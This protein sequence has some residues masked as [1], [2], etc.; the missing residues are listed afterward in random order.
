MLLMVALSATIQTSDA[1]AS[2]FRNPPAWA[3]PHT[4]WHWMDGNVT[5]EG[6]TA[7]LEAMKQVGIGGAQMFTVSQGIPPGKAGY[8]SPE[9]RIMT[10]F[11]VDEANRL[12]VELCIHNCAGWSS[13]GGP[14]IKPEDAMQVLAWSEVRVSGPSAMHQTLPQPKAPQVYAKVDYYK[15]IEVYAFPT[16]QGSVPV[17]RGEQLGRT[18]VVRSDGLQ[19]NISSPI[20]GIPKAA[21]IDIT[22]HLRDGVLD[23]DVPAGDW[24]ILRLGHVPTGIDNH[25]APPE[26]DGLE[27]DKLSRHALDNHWAGMMAKVLSDVG[28]LAGKSLN[29]A[30]IDSYEVGSQNWTPKFRSEFRRL[31]GYDPMPY[32]PAIAGYNVQ[33]KDVTER[34]LWDMRRTIA[35]LYAENYFGY[36]AELCHRAGL[37]FSTEPYGD[38]GFDNIQAGSTADIPMGEFWIGG[39]AI[40]STKL[41]SSIGHVYGKNVIGAESFTAD[42]IRGRFLEEP[43]MLKTI[44]DLAWCNGINRYIFHRYAMQPWMNFKPGMT[45]GP[46]GTH[47]ERTQTWWKEAATWLKYV[48]RGQYLLQSGQFVADAIVYNGD[49]APQDLPYS[50]GQGRVVPTGYDYDGC[51]KKALL[52]MTVRQGRVVLPSGMSYSLLI[53]PKSDFM[54]LQ[55]AQKIRQLRDSGA[56]IIG[57]EPHFSPTLANW[58]TAESQMRQIVG[59]LFSRTSLKS[60][61]SIT[62]AVAFMQIGLKPDFEYK[63]LSGGSKL[64]YIHRRLDGAE[65]YYVANQKYSNTSVD[66]TFRVDDQAPELWHPESGFIEPATVYRAAGGRTT[67]QLNLGSAESV[68]VV[69]RKRSDKAHLTS[70]STATS[71][72]TTA[73]QPT[74]LIDRARY[75]SADGRGVDVTAKVRELLQ[76]GDVEISATNSNFGDPIVNVVKHLVVEY[77]VNGKPHKVTV[78]ENE[79]VSLATAGPQSVGPANYDL[80]RLNDSRYELVQWNPS[81]YVASSSKGVSKRIPFVGGNEQLD[82]SKNWTVNFPPKLGAPAWATFDKLQSFTLNDDDGIKYFSGTATYSK[83]FDVPSALVSPRRA[84][85][86]DLGDVKNFATIVLNGRVL[87][88]LWKPPFSLDVSGFVK[89][90]QNRLEVRVTNLWVNRMIGDEQLPPDVE[91]DGMQLKKWPDWLVEGKPRPE[92]GRITFSTWHFWRKDSPLLES[93]LLGPVIL[94]SAPKTVVTL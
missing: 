9:W 71:L 25:P 55:V 29:N 37:K 65:I 21:I 61:K 22:A 16:P 1:L 53:L 23:W 14:W 64:C 82:L 63:S 93:G 87:A 73:K 69:F 41:A 26:G 3:R 76:Q 68:F 19:P 48:A 13:S 70:F 36:F 46:W 57:S 6:I 20:A 33:S 27:V 38:G 5:K 42:D 31:R 35:D 78:A 85:R 90:G 74:I 50:A 94:R 4:W 2:G 44:G 77:R 47:L 15:D 43:Y 52:S 8:M 7:D 30:L 84:M 72:A 12:G 58:P 75:E 51:D 39:L 79:A 62:S 54:T 59:P 11:A 66:A 24:T 18:G 34:F 67:V 40:E 86:L 45:M 88:T 91:W 83:T 92:T 81:S 49:N 28:P 10:A 60:I 89:A 32:L 17:V 56:V 80:R